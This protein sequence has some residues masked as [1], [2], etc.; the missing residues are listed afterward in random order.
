M[1]DPEPDPKLDPE[2]DPEPDPNPKLLLPVEPV[3]PVEPPD[4]LFGCPV[5]AFWPKLL[6]DWEPIPP[7]PVGM[8]LA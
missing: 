4:P 5:T 6:A 2:P 1:L 7:P 8:P 3:E